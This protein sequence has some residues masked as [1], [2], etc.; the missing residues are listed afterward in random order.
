MTTQRTQYL[1]LDQ[2]Y[3]WNEDPPEKVVAGLATA[4]DGSRQL[5]ALPGLSS[6]LLDAA[7][8]EKAFV[9]PSGVAIGP[10]GTIGVVDAATNRV[11]L[12]EPVR[13]EIETIATIGGKGG[14]PRSLLE[15]RGIAFLKSG[16]LVIADTA[17][18]RVQIY[19]DTQHAL[20]Q[21]WGA[22]D[23]L[24]NPTAGAGKKSFQW[25]W[26]VTTDGCGTVFVI[27]RGNHRI[28]KVLED[29]TWLEEIG[30][31]YLVDPTRVALGPDG[32]IA[33]VD[34]TQQAVLLFSPRRNLPRS[35]TNIKDP[36]SVEFGPDGMLYVGDATGLIGVYSPVPDNKDKYEL[37][38][39]GNASVDGEIVDLAWA[40][41]SSPFLLAVIKENYN[42]LRQRLWRIEPVGT[43]QHEGRL[44][45]KA[46]DSR[47]EK[48]QWHRVLL[49]AS[50]PA[51]EGLTN[52]SASGR[53]DFGAASIE[54]ESHTSDVSDDVSGWNLPDSNWTRCLLSG[55]N[56]PDCLVQSGPGRYLWLR[57]TLRSNGIA[58]PILRRIKAFSPRISYLQYLPAVYQEDTESRLFLDRFLSI[59]QTEFDNF[60]H[61]ID[62]VWR[63]FDPA[64]VSESHFDWLAGWLGLVIQ[65]DSLLDQSCR[66]ECLTEQSCQP[67]PKCPPASNDETLAEN[68]PQLEWSSEKKRQMLKNA[69]SAYRVRGT[70]KG[71]E[72][73]IQDHTGVQFAKVLEHFRLRRWP[74]LS[75]VANP[76]QSSAADPCATV[77]AP[78]KTGSCGETIQD[79]KF[80]LPLD[81]TVRLWSRDFYK[82]L[83]LTSYSQLGY[84]RLTGTPE[85]VLEPFD[86]GANRFTVFFP[87]SP[88]SVAETSH[89]VQQVLEREKPAHTQAELC[90]VL[91]RLR[92]GVQATI[93]ADAVVGGISHLVLN[94]LST[95]NYDSILA[96]SAE[97]QQLRARGSARRLRAGI[98]T[99]LA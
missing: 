28:Q 8:Q 32:L 94:I 61:Q 88:Y 20:V 44:V 62:E 89:K 26:S 54:I 79:Y 70:V 13:Q 53:I 30:R 5:F 92:V 21:S 74:V 58:S 16:A 24:G 87:A 35:L 10:L 75:V 68:T 11:T 49:S 59:F 64:S 19:S 51:K 48:C 78:V 85:P 83:Q 80:S 65:P 23:P 3:G 55:D 7:S 43:F 18:H 27:D 1:I 37:V 69:F 86:W 31:D 82:R 66:Y 42:G 96:C 45:T 95:L 93:G 33:V 22:L 6:L 15:P 29:G 38:G 25:P 57:L 4:A 39:Q 91:P 47:L 84:F 67:P 81:G 46:I 97:E 52:S 36:R 2:V 76:E 98:T 77:E 34:S 73:A 72:R 12:I 90:P 60:D 56:D 9:C 63:L 41:G 99:R 50:M 40:S 14:S 17:N 71:V